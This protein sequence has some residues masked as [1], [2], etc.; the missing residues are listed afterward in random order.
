MTNKKKGKKKNK[1]SFS[2]ACGS[3]TW[4]VNFYSTACFDFFGCY[5][6]GG[7]GLMSKT[8][9]HAQ[10]FPFLVPLPTNATNPPC[11]LHIYIYMDEC[12]SFSFSLSFFPSY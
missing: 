11:F 6:L 4:C 9:V 5:C 8:F 1:G 2:E 12:I 3:E 7:C 10:E